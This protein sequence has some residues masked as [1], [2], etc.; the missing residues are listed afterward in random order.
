MT[1]RILGICVAMSVLMTTSAFA[2]RGERREPPK[3]EELVKRLDTDK[4][5]K[6]SKAEAEVAP[7]GRLKEH[8]DKIDANEDGFIEAKELE[9]FHNKIRE[10]HRGNK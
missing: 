6:I 5:G 3:P 4:D 2:Q 10:K 1:K 7:R 8:F 9:D